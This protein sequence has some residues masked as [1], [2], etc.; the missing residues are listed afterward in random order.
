MKAMTILVTALGL[1]LGV[2][3]AAGQPTNCY[4]ISSLEP[5]AS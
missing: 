5:G 4:A 2:G 1:A 3:A